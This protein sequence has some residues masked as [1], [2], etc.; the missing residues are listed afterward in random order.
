MSKSGVVTVV[1]AFELG[2]ADAVHVAGVK[3]PRVALHDVGARPWT[4][5]GASRLPASR[6]A[7][8]RRRVAAPRPVVTNAEP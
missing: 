5:A 1:A 7:L 2:G 3:E 8:L 6:N 4:S